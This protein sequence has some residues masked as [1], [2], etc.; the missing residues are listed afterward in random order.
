MLNKV[1]NE[2]VNLTFSLR[3]H[4]MCCVSNTIVPMSYLP[5]SYNYDSRLNKLY[6]SYFVNV[7]IVGEPEIQKLEK[8]GRKVAEF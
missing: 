3:L 6:K 2:Y 7:G 1:A 5:T 4:A 8:S